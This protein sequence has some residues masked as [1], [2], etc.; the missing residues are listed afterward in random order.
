MMFHASLL[1]G[2]TDL[3]SDSCADRSSIL[4]IPSQAQRFDHKAISHFAV[5]KHDG[6]TFLDCKCQRRLMA[7]WH[8]VLWRQTIKAC[9][10]HTK[11]HRC[12]RLRTEVGGKCFLD[13]WGMRHATHPGSFECGSHVHLLTLR[14]VLLN[15][16]VSSSSYSLQWLAFLQRVAIKSG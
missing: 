8:L 5:N 1:P 7:P 12:D 6:R 16:D 2:R 15:L 9:L 4:Y 10:K 13:V 14:G 3:H 11:T